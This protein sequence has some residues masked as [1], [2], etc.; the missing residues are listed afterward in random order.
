MLFH[1]R[2]IIPPLWIL[3]AIVAGSA[4]ADEIR[5]RDGEV[6]FGVVTGRTRS[7]LVVET[8]ANVRRL[9]RADVSEH[10]DGEA[11]H[12]VLAR[13]EV[14]LSA[15]DARGRA[16]LAA[17]AWRHRM[18]EAARR[19]A[20]AAVALES[21]LA[22]ARSLLG[23]RREESTWV[24]GWPAPWGTAGIVGPRWGEARQRAWS[25]GGGRAPARR[26]LEAGLRW[27]AVHQDRDGKLDA[28]GFPRHDPPEDPCD[29]TGGG[30]HGER[31]P[32]AFDGAV[33]G[34]TLLAWLGAGST[35]VSGPYQ[36]NVEKALGWCMRAME[37]GPASA[38]D[39]WNHAFL[40]Q[41]VADAYL[42]T[43][44]PA[45]GEALESQ[46]EALLRHQLEDGGFSYY[47]AISDVPTTAAVATALGLAAQ[48]GV[49]IE[50]RRMERILS[51]LDARL[52]RRSG[53]SEY[54]DG[55]EKKGYT[56][57]RANAAA[58]LTVRAYLG[59]LESAP[60]LDAQVEAISNRPPRWSIKFKEVKASD[61]RK[62]RAQIGNLYPYQWYYTTLALSHHGGATQARWFKA[63]QAALVKGQRRTGSARGS[64]DPLGQYSTS[65]GRVFVTAICVLMLEAPF[66]YPGG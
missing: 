4:R 29:G 43:R 59:R 42:V 26:A 54:H 61:G 66:R 27:L 3:L 11:P 19:L 28:D 10:L 48:A 49:V 50:A 62:V 32:C 41:A 57:T 21:D 60:L 47:M 15:G 63:L 37:G 20:R 5:M 46:V 40:T 6:I 16:E 36:K 65:A 33:T 53:R 18:D 12:C 31:E 56:P 35:P 22:K 1:S 25:A 52:D 7:R 17:F 9:R 8:A 13:R 64:W 24:K 34:V 38:Y 45:L 30:H 58:A 44:D 51:Y 14:A 2:R 23:E 39:L 55:A